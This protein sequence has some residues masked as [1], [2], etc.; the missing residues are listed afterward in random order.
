M[1]RKPRDG[2]VPSLND[3]A[4][5]VAQRMMDR[6]AD[7][8]VAVDRST[9]AA[10]ID[11]GVHA[12]GSL[13]AGLEMARLCLAELAD[14]QLT[15]TR[16]AG[17]MLPGVAVHVTHPIPACMASQYAGRQIALDDFFA[18]GSGPMRA[19]WPGEALFDDIG[20]TEQPLK[21]IGALESARL[22][23]LAVIEHIAKSCNVPLH[24]IGLVVAPTASLAG[25]V[26]VVARSVETAMHKLHE[27]KFDLRQI[28][29]GY[30]LAPLPPVAA[31]DMAAIGRTNDAILYGA[32][33]VLIVEADD[34]Q[35]RE[36]GASLPSSASRDYGKPFAEVFAGYGHDFYKVDPML[37]SPA[38]VSFQNLKTGRTHH[39]GKVNHDVLER[40]FF[41]ATASEPPEPRA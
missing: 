12:P 24:R 1:A 2:G 4:A 40:S 34:D 5:D 14:V 22:P 13:A 11:A 17:R 8:G 33:V 16:V 27:L 3:R 19:A 7:L 10:V 26:Q 41:D 21:I 25:G 20:F 32:E 37:F 36:V 38:V 15:P 6:A 28:V 30:G 39:F 9:T 29:S 31:D 23:G 18:M 35:L